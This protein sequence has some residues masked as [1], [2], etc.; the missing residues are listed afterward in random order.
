MRRG[1]IRN[2]AGLPDAPL[3]LG[4]RTLTMPAPA[5]DRDINTVWTTEH[6]LK[7]LVILMP[8]S[9][10][11]V[12]GAGETVDPTVLLKVEAVL[13]ETGIAMID[14]PDP[15]VPGGVAL[16]TWRNTP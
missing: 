12:F 11:P 5:R 7:N 16:R 15:L 14:T 1:K 8:S 3:P 2:A 10:C 4:N 9:N 6:L 13:G